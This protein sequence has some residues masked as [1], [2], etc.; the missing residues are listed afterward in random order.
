MATMIKHVTRILLAGSMMGLSIMTAAHNPQN[1]AEVKIG[2][3]VPLSGAQAHYGRDFLNGV[4]LAVEEFNAT[5]PII[6]GKPIRIVLN[7]M[8]DRADPRMAIM[9][10]KKLVDQKI[11]G[12]LGHFNSGTTIP[13][14]HIYA[15][16]GIPQIAMASA[17]QYT[18]QG[19]KT[20]F[21]MTASDLQ[22][23]AVI[24]ALVA[25]NLGLKR[26]AIIDDRTTYGQ[27]LADQ[28]AQIATAEG[29]NIVGREYGNDKTIDFKALLTRLKRIKPQAIFYGGVDAQAAAVVKQMQAL[30]IKAVLIASE[31]V[32]SETFLKLAGP[33]AEGTV[34][35][36]ICLSPDKMPRGQ[37]YAEHYQKRFGEKVQTYSPY[38]YDGAMAMLG[39]MKTADA[40]EPEKYLPYLAQ[41]EMPA[42]TIKT[43]AY[44]AHGDLK[45]SDMVVYKVVNGQ[46]HTLSIIRGK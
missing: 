37:E 44:N 29:V 42:I 7:T 38:A 33:A 20:T 11:K 17:P 1:H 9:V 24:S 41:T 36:S 35:L 25:K 19:Y 10:A 28:F 13:A 3:A 46:W 30:K 14:S 34:A 32:K 5:H 2:C 23:D 4:I 22:Q 45:Q 12:V 31:G 8:D 27:A 39:A 16:A 18:Q 26:I 15:K 21:R 40:T 6:G 43:L